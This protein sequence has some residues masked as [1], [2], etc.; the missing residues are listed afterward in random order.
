MTFPVFILDL[1]T[2][3]ISIMIN[4]ITPTP[5]SFQPLKYNATL[6]NLYSNDLIKMH[7]I[8]F[9]HSYPRFVKEYVI[10]FNY[11]GKKLECFPCK[12]QNSKYFR[13]VIKMTFL[14]TSQLCSYTMKTV[15][16]DT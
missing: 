14:V 9:S 8:V 10:T 5:L 6:A 11:L 16:G 4:Y 2:T 1:G 13:P 3:R 15:K 7:P 12:A